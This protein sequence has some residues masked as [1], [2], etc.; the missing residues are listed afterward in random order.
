MFSSVWGSHG[1]RTRCMYRVWRK[2]LVFQNG[3]SYISVSKGCKWI[4]WT[5]NFGSYS[6]KV[7]KCVPR[8]I[9]STICVCKYIQLR[10]ILLPSYTCGT[11]LHS[12]ELCTHSLKDAWE[13][14]M[15][16]IRKCQ[17]IAPSHTLLS[18]N[19]CCGCPVLWWT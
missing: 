2:A 11:L 6:A 14:I 8:Q 12:L 13:I 19:W 1:G 16:S 15:I 10:Q 7:N 18:E 3:M 17:V 5:N 4:N 9:E